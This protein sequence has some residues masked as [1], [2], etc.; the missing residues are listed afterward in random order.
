M[1]ASEAYLDALL[2]LPD[3]RNPQVSRDA[4][5]VAWDWL[6]AGPASNVFAVPSDGSSGPLQL[7][8]TPE[9]TFLVSWAPDS[10][11]LVVRQDRGG[12]ERFQL[13]RVDL[14]RP[15]V[16]VPLTPADPPYFL[17]GG[18][19]HP[20]GRWLI[21]AAN[22]DF[23]AKQVIE[24][25]W[26]YRLDL[27]TGEYKLLARPQ[28][29]GFIWPLL[30]PAGDHILYNRVDR[31]PAGRQVW[32]VDTE[33]RSDREIFSLGDEFKV[34]ASWFPDGRRVL[35]QA[36]VR[37][38]RKL[39]VWDL[40]SE[41]IYWL[42]DDP[43]RNIENACVPF[44]SHLVLVHEVRQARSRPCLVD[45][46]SAAETK[47]PALPGNLIPLAPLSGGY[48]VGQYSSS[49]QPGEIVRFR[50]GDYDPARFPGLARVWE[51]TP[52]RPADLVPAEDF[53]WASVD[54]LQI[55]GWLYRAA[56]VQRGTVVFVHGGPTYHSTDRIL[57][58]IQYLTHSG[59]TVFDPNYRGS[60]GFSLLFRNAIK[61]DGWG[62]SEQEDIRTGIEAL[63]QAGIA[64]KGKVGITGTSFGGYSTWH[65]ATHLG[66][67]LLAAAAPICGMTDLVL[68]YH[69]T[70]PDLR[71]LSEE[72]L[73]GTPEQ[74]PE[75][76]FQRSPINFLPN[77]HARLLIVQGMQDPNV[78]PENVRA[79]CAGLE[80]AH[81][82]YE[83]LPFA[84]EGHGIY[85]P[86]NQRIL[87]RKLAEF[88]SR[89]F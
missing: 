51:R 73:G 55:Q 49:R 71:P 57:A 44:R 54:G 4:R 35:I 80:Q 32:L 77:V 11:S 23:A 56:G 27:V 40:P 21:F 70:R 8:N 67:D 89:A 81:V 47:L 20:N 50:P 15:G 5:W 82:P 48:W 3:L 78:S 19:L 60:T 31:H 2:S 42:I 24:P 43:T 46:R 41:R 86:A 16:M 7:T 18:E 65:A 17:R 12:N 63:I 62:G 10:Q 6:N 29:P 14:V 22:Y 72:M 30:S 37:T 26:I 68:D 33:G 9:Q 75:R 1:T 13:F 76:Y 52:L 59:F 53:H 66:R 25:T 87:F 79:V 34:A 38:H 28:R 84:D 58:L 36:D 39:G 61:V 64:S 85:R 69:T 88:F 74:A 83:L 45:P